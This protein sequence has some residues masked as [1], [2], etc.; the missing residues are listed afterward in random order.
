MYPVFL[1]IEYNIQG[2]SIIH[3]KLHFDFQYFK[4]VNC[5]KVSIFKLYL[6]FYY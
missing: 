3:R 1:K 5:S 6:N 2:Y 4:E